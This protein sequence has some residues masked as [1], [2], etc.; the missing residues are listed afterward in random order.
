M[1]NRPWFKNRTFTKLI[2][3]E[4]LDEY[5]RVWTSVS[6]FVIRKDILYL[7]KLYM[8]LMGNPRQQDFQQSIQVLLFKRLKDCC[9]LETRKSIPSIFQEFLTDVQ[10]MGELTQ[11]M[12][13]ELLVNPSEIP[14]LEVNQPQK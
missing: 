11:N 4:N 9:V 2:K 5:E 8:L 6:Q 14:E 12:M 7:V 13:S 10:R 1:P 3:Q